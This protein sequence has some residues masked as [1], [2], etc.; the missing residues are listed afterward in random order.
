[1]PFWW[2]W[3]VRECVVKV[4]ER[5]VMRAGTRNGRVERDPMVILYACIEVSDSEIT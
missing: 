2:H 3:E 1:M 5:M 4:L